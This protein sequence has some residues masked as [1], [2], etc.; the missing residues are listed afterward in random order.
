MCKGFS[1]CAVMQLDTQVIAQRGMSRCVLDCKG[2][3]ITHMIAPMQLCN[4]IKN[5][6][7]FSFRNY[8][9]YTLSQI[10]GASPV[11]VTSC[12]CLFEYSTLFYIHTTKQNKNRSNPFKALTYSCIE[13]N[14]F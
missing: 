10:Q 5:W 7:L 4:T 12:G 2:V 1:P 9:C 8:F 11:L 14:M 13:S 6:P 3:R